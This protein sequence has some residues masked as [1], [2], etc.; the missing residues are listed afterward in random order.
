[1]TGHPTRPLQDVAEALAGFERRGRSAANVRRGAGG[2]AIIVALV[3]I[4]LLVVGAIIAGGREQDL[5]IQRVDSTRAFYACEAGENLS[6]RECL[7]GADEDHDGVIGT[8]SNNNNALDDPA[9]GPAMFSVS[10]QMVSG[11]AQFVPAGRSGLSRRK[12]N[13][14][15]SGIIGGVPQT[16]LAGF[17]KGTNTQPRYSTWNGSG[18]NSSVNMPDI[19]GQ[20]KWVRMKICPTRNETCMIVEDLSKRV[21]VLFFNGTS[22]SAPYLVSTD[23]GGTN[24]R[25]EDLGYEQLTSRGLCVY[26]RGTIGKFGYRLYDGTSFSA[27]QTIANPFSTECDFLTLCPRPS[28]NEIMMLASDGNLGGP[29]VGA[30]WNGTAFSSWTQ[31]VASLDNNNQECF[32]MAYESSSGT[33]VATYIETGVQTPRYRTFNGSTWSA[34]GSLPTIGA[35]GK[36]LRMAADPTS[37]KILFA[38]LDDQSDI[39]TNC[40]NG[41]WGTNQEL[42][43]NCPGYL[44]RAFDILYERGTGHALIV[45]AQTGATNFKYRTWNGSAWSA[46]QAGPSMGAVGSLV[47][48]SR[49][50]ANGEVFAAISDASM[51]LHLFRWNG[52]SWGTDTII[53]STL[54]GWSNYFSFT[55]PEPTV[56]P[57]PRLTSWAEVTP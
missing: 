48:L 21:N 49:G 10:K 38:S 27:E 11:H 35:V 22:W 17:G 47:S 45:Y 36:W 42:A 18:W 41:S 29:L 55:V 34:Q 53:E 9:L 39:N 13:A 51:R 23:T 31:L 33:G 3:I 50:F 25:P 5:S 7:N 26:W 46:E 24:D 32:A 1:M 20:P 56:A 57:H 37:N 2:V 30:Y 40:W 6:M 54:S 19:G 28:S 12:T 4:Q 8:V 16:I 44:G 43:A 52:S 15:V 14:L